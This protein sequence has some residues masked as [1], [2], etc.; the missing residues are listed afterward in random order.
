MKENAPP[1][2]LLV[3]DEPHVLA[4]LCRHL[5]RRFDAVSAVGSPAG[6]DALRREG[7]FAVVVSDLRM[8]EMDGIAFLA[9]VRQEAPDTVRILLTG[10][11]DIHDAVALVNTVNVF[12]FLRKP[13][14]PEE[15]LASLEAA[16]EQHRLL[17][18]ER[19]LLE[20]TLHGS[21]KALTDLLALVNP[22]AFGKAQRAKR[23]VERV[24]IHMQVPN[25]WQIEIAAML[26]QVGT[27]VLAPNTVEKL[28]HGDTLTEAERANASRLPRIA[29]DL[30]AQIPRLEEVREILLNYEK[31]TD[32]T[33]T[34]AAPTNEASSYELP[35]GARILKAALDL[36]TLEGTGM[37]PDVSIATLRSRAGRYDPAVLEAL[38]AV[39]GAAHLEINV[40][41]VPLREVRPGMVFVNEVKTRAGLLLIARGQEVTRGLVER[42]QCA[43]QGIDVGQMARVQVPPPPEQAAPADP[44][45][46]LARSREA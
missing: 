45:R 30:I 3:D 15:L 8:P 4:G 33:G 6:L 44:Q 28:H 14:P 41:E 20:Q 17:T 43:A 26:S 22:A 11:A 2:V 19:V 9:R 12:R 42:L 32:G 40:L 13:C 25:R 34:N 24:A 35:I 5:R 16:V 36:D 39:R 29:A 31:R 1:R 7:P 18:A 38:E 23:L 27:I 10:H 21:I 37:P 46:E